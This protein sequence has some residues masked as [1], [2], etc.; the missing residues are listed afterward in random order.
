M[1]EIAEDELSPW[2]PPRYTVNRDGKVVG[3]TPEVPNNWGRWGAFDQLGT[4]NLL[5]DDR[6]AAAARLVRTGQRISLAIPVGKKVPSPGS[7]AEVQHFFGRTTTDQLV[8]DPG[9]AGVQ[10][11]DDTV[12]LSLQ[13]ATQLDGLAHVGYEDVLY[14]GYWAGLV[15]A[16]AGA[17]R[18]GIHHQRHGVTG[19]GVL[20]DVAGTLE[21]DPFGTNIGS[22]MLDEVAAAHGIEVRAG[23]IVLVRTGFLAAWY[24]DPKVRHRRRSA[25]L[26]E[27]TIDWLAHHDIAMVAADNRAVEV[28]PNPDSA[29]PLP[30]HVAALRDLGL[31]VGELFDLDHL[32]AA[33][34]AES[35]YEFF[36]TCAPL[37]LRNAVGSPL[38]PL[39]IL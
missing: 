8:G 19:R 15:T 7:R 13:G 38:N 34:R 37:P 27:G 4:A 30:F 6:V 18:L 17:R 12:V 31:L 1:R 32:A 20:L 35:R 36:F 33:C 2:S 25:G 3:A 26:G 21:I 14:N 10:S 23:D 11:S 24:A 39:A 5:T 28:V 9:P 22:D 29:L 16:Q